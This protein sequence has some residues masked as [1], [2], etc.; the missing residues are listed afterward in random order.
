MVESP[1]PALRTSGRDLGTSREEAGKEVIW[2]RDRSP[3]MPAGE[4][5]ASPFCLGPWSPL[6]PHEEQLE[7]ECSQRQMTAAFSRRE[8]GLQGA[9]G[10]FEYSHLKGRV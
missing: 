8:M 1:W 4:A 5:L 9:K 7:G 10:S 3:P 2:G 6:L